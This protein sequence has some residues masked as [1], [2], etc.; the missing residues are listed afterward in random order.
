VTSDERKKDAEVQTTFREN[1]T[2]A[3]K[4]LQR[5]CFGLL[6]LHERFRGRELLAVAAR[7]RPHTLRI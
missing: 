6:A 1:E 4:S 2:A 5:R 3:L 7:T